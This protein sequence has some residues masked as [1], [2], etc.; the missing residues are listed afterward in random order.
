MVSTFVIEDVAEVARWAK[1][2]EGVSALRDDSGVP[3]LRNGTQESRL[4]NWRSRSG[5]CATPYGVQHLQPVHSARRP[6]SRRSQGLRGGAWS[7][8]HGVLVVDETGFLRRR[9]T[10][11]ERV[12]RLSIACTAGRMS[13]IHRGIFDLR[14][15]QGEDPGPGT[16]PA[17][18]VG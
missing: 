7:D 9:G 10:S 15:C 2:I 4:G 12:Q 17:S 11:V 16:L 14:L 8:V 18:R 6:G 5:G 1:G 3:S 13:T